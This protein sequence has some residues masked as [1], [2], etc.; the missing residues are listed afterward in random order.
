MTTKIKP[1][2]TTSKLVAIAAAGVAWIAMLSSAPAAPK[3]HPAPKGAVVAACARTSACLF[4]G[5]Y[6]NTNTGN[7]GHG[8]SFRCDK[9]QCWPL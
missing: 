4:D 6:G 1:N 2:R 9:T 5:T 7:N 3:G 8:T